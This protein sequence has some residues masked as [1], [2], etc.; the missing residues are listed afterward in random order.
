VAAVAISFVAVPVSDVH[1]TVLAV[2][3]T[4]LVVHFILFPL[5]F[6]NITLETDE[7]TLTFTR[8]ALVLAVINISICVEQLTN[9]TA[10]T[11]VEQT[12]EDEVG[13]G[14]L[15]QQATH[16]VELVIFETP[17]VNV[18]IRGHVH[19]TVLAHVILPKSSEH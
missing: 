7:F 5:S 8:K 19:L 16:A 11:L 9:S 6:V 2:N 4:A 17:N 18:T 15:E 1:I 12:F 14:S 3:K 13:V 10:D